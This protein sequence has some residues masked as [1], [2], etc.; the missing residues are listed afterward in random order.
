MKPLM[1]IMA[2]GLAS[3][4]AVA[5]APL[6]ET[7]MAQ[8]AS[9]VSKTTIGKKYQLNMPLMAQSG[10]QINTDASATIVQQVTHPGA[11]Y[12]KLHF[13][14]LNLANGGKLVVRSQSGNERYQY[15]QDDLVAA[16]V[17]AAAGD[18]GLKHFSAMSVSDDTVIIEYTPGAGKPDKLATIDY[19][20][21]GVAGQQAI[22]NLNDASP[23][24]TCGAMERRDVQCWAQSNPV[25]FERT[26]PVAR[27]L[28][29]GSG[30]CTG[31]RVGP[32]NRMFTN[33]HCVET[34]SELANT[35][36]WFN[37]QHTSCNGSVKETVVKV[38]GKDFLATD[39]TLD[40]TLFSINDFA[41]AAP[42]GYFGL[43]VR[44]PS[45]G[46]RIYIPQ[47]GAGNPKE[48]SIESDQDSNGLCSVNEPNANG[49]GTGTDIGY[50]CDT[51]GGSSGSPVLAA[52]SNNVIAL[53]H[54]GGCT[55]KGAKISQIW[56]QVS[57]HFGGEIPVGDNGSSDP[58]PVA[59]FT[60]NCSDL[61]C[62]FD[63]S[64][65]SSGDPITD[66]AWQFSDGTAG[67]GAQL[68]H[69]FSS[70]GDYTVALTVTDSNGAT[71]TTSQLVSV[72]LPGN[73]QQLQPGVAKTDLSGARGDEVFYYYDAPQGVSNVT[74]TMS[75]GSGDADMYVRKGEQPT[76]AT[77]D[78]RPYRWGNDESCNQSD[79]GGR[80]WVMIRGYNA[81]SGVQL[82]ANHN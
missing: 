23:L 42:F 41:K 7:Q 25:E 53:H 21:H 59:Y 49:R 13:K 29:N 36:V 57:S 68:T 51:T 65:S 33:N 77:W 45:Q 67:N 47:H 14:H 27:L 26:R 82:V 39:Y 63:G 52:A 15:T 73:E 18:D 55:N 2:M 80:Y 37:Y 38:T 56:P 40:Y 11:S 58:Q 19:Y 8:Y 81:Y 70:A 66:F 6:N 72:S 30:L 20:Y 5:N 74:F 62:S 17:D 4:L 32:D 71:A 22:A 12:I 60:Y 61:S 76:T 24:S 28:M 46:E 54:L 48:L 78:C 1:L 35:E 50:Y 75:G 10:D 3:N 44:D 69:Q 16:T 9:S 64:S 43:D 31:W 34:A 79:G